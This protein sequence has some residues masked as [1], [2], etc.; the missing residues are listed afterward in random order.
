MQ[1]VVEEAQVEFAAEVLCYVKSRGR[2]AVRLDDG[3]TAAASSEQLRLSA[4][5]GEWTRMDATATLSVASASGGCCGG[6]CTDNDGGGGSGGEGCAGGCA[7]VDSADAACSE[8][9]VATRLL[10]D[11]WSDEQRA[12]V[13]LVPAE[14]VGGG[15]SDDAAGWEAKYAALATNLGHAPSTVDAFALAQQVRAS[16]TSKAS[17]LPSTSQPM[18]T[19]MAADGPESKRLCG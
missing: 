5:P 14:G 1:V 15:D 6:S 12:L 11:R 2:W 17:C 10:G 16:V 8:V 13:A 3:R 9:G 7:R 19:F 18:I 4:M